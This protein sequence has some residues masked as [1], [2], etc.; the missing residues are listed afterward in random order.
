MKIRVKIKKI[1][2]DM[3]NDMDIAKFPKINIR[4]LEEKLEGKK[5]EIEFEFK[6][7]YDNNSIIMKGTAFIEERGKEEDKLDKEELTE[8]T[9]AINYI[10]GVNGVLI[11]KIFGIRSPLIPPRIGLK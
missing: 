1:E 5:G 2:V 10:C 9:N 3:E 11:A 7:E 4:Y 8:L 6:A